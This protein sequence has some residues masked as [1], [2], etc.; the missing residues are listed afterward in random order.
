M[1]TISGPFPAGGLLFGTFSVLFLYL[2][3]ICF[4]TF[5]LVLLRYVLGSFSS[6]VRY[7]FGAC[8]FLTLLVSWLVASLVASLGRSLVAQLV[9]WV[10]A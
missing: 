9:G 2:F 4:V 7:F 10:V 6:H 1:G 5:F 3:D 8:S